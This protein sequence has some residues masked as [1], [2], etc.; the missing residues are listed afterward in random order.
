MEG[1]G[2]PRLAASAGMIL[3][4][5]LP[6]CRKEDPRIREL[7]EQ[8]AHADEASQALRRAWVEQLGRFARI[9]LADPPPGPPL[10]L[11]S[12]EQKRALEARVGLERDSSR[13][14]LLLEVL[15]KD[16]ELGA[17]QA[18]LA[19][20]KAR[21]PEP[22]IARRNDSHYGLALRFLLGRGCTAEQARA[23]LSRVTISERIA[24]GY[25]VYHFLV[26]GAYGTWVAQGAAPVS[27]RELV[28]DGDRLQLLSERDR[29]VGRGGRLQKELAALEREKQAIERD[30]T[31]LRLEHR[32]ALEGGLLLQADNAHQL[33]RLN[34]LHYL[35]GVRETLERDGIIE[36]P[37]LDRDRSGR[38]W[39]DTLFTES[40]DLRT[41]TTL[42]IR[43]RDLGLKCIGS[44]S[45]VPG[46]YLRG[47][48]YE[49]VLSPDRQTATVELRAPAR[50]KNDKVVFAVA[51]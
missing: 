9:H 8:A 25:E 19:Q 15:A 16:A 49:L 50:F 17:L 39:H 40:L 41:G 31:A 22:E 14:A 7:T 24:P 48:H 4:A 10:M 26:D 3:L 13:R 23:L 28:D 47:E 32:Q 36:T 21:L 37:I 34:A 20:L 6:G 27:P 51:E 46:S 42:Q 30:M 5:V 43:A 2:W 18:E 44:V 11:L 38:N 45:V 29:A 12:Q 35:V 33:A 1:V